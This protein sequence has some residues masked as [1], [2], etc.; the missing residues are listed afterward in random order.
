MTQQCAIDY[1]WRQVVISDRNACW[2]WSGPKTNKGYGQFQTTAFG[3]R[4]AHKLSWMLSG[5]E[6]LDG[7]HVLHRCD[8]RAC[9]NPAHLFLGTNQDNVTDK[10]QKGR[11]RG[12]ARLTEAQVTQIVN[13]PPTRG[14]GNALANALGVTRSQ[15]SKI[16]H[17][18][19]WRHL[20]TQR[21]EQ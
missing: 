13:T 14:S 2:C 10:M 16:R 6:I 1:F 3:E 9:V 21:K 4:K 20:T 7:L 18:K 8:N 12:P 15:I 19:T 11:W 5:H 17:G